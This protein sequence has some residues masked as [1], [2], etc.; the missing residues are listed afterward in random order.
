MDCHYVGELLLDHIEGELPDEIS[1][2]IEAHLR[3]CESCSKEFA[4]M[5]KMVNLMKT[6]PS[7]TPTPKITQEVMAKL[8]KE[9]ELTSRSFLAKFN[10]FPKKVM[11]AAATLGVLACVLYGTMNLFVRPPSFQFKTWAATVQAVP[12]D[13]EETGWW[14]WRKKTADERL[15]S[16]DKYI[17]VI[18][19]GIL[20]Q[21][22][23]VNFLVKWI[24]P[25]GHPFKEV[26][27]KGRIS[28][29]LCSFMSDLDIND[30]KER[31]VRESVLTAF[32]NGEMIC[33]KQEGL[34]N[35]SPGTWKLE[36]YIN[37]KLNTTLQIEV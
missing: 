22:K 3:K 13:L 7:I 10:F 17:G 31:N 12:F 11:I 18:F 19:G 1:R 29:G 28:A 14:A 23:D 9:E 21:P 8:E 35:D 27:W 30:Y 36:I 20:D 24:K 25:N 4:R 34:V 37:N 15:L 32:F 6:I 26:V 33:K 2:K 5:Q 16:E